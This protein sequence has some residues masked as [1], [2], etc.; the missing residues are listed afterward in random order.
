MNNPKTPKNNLVGM[1][2][3]SWLLRIKNPPLISKKKPCSLKIGVILEVL[4]LDACMIFVINV[5]RISA[6]KACF[7]GIKTVNPDKRIIGIANPTMPLTRPPRKPI[8]KLIK[9][10]IGSNWKKSNNILTK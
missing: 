9:S 6:A 4:W 8:P 1:W 3:V 2:G 5:G 7:A 10:N